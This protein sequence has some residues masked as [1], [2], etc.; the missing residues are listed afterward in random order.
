MK[1]DKISLRGARPE[2]FTSDVWE[3]GASRH[4]GRPIEGPP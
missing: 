4:D 2:I 1:E 3:A